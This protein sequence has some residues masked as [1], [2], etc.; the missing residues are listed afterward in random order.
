MRQRVAAIILS[1]KKILLVRDGKTQKFFPPGGGIEEGE[2]HQAALS[3]ELAEELSLMLMKC[4]FYITCEG[5]HE[6]SGKGQED[7]CYITEVS[8]TPLPCAEI[9]ELKWLSKEELRNETVPLFSYYK[10]SLFLKLE[11]DGFI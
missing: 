2:T 7:H 8:G 3:R 6:R 4:T 11:K 5:I 10:D 9:C 1:D